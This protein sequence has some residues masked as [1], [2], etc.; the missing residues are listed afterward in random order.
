MATDVRF[1][2]QGGLEL[3]DSGVAERLAI[4]GFSPQDADNLR[5][6]RQAIEPHVD[7]LAS[8]FFAHLDGLPQARNALRTAGVYEEARALKKAHL[9]AMVAGTYGKP[10]AEERLR[11][12]RLYARAGLESRAFLGAFRAMM[13]G[14]AQRIAAD[15]RQPAE[16]LARIAA[17]ERLG[18][19]DV[20][21]IVDAIVAEGERV[22]GLQQESILELSTPVLRLR[23]GLVILPII[24]VLDTDRARRLT[25]QL[26]EGIHEARARIVVLDVTGVPLVDS[27]VAGHLI[28]TVEAA[29]VMGAEAI[30]TG[31]SPA[32]A[33]TL[34]TLGLELSGLLTAG[35]LQSGLEMAER[36]LA[37][38][39]A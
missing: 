8:T 32:V 34:A 30:V 28:L 36:L 39:A 3:D 10:Y 14:I 27:K 37:R 1:I 23:D 5:S 20:G 6:I 31:L 15:E 24:G 29:R 4:A 35:D 7:E 9:R 19:F 2:D 18:A 26:L 16:I 21:L 33:Q 22:I 13:S 38:R 11:L 25:E 12:G 17:L